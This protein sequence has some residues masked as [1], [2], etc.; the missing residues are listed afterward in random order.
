[1]S[2]TTVNDKFQLARAQAMHEREI[3]LQMSKSDHEDVAKCYS[4]LTR[5]RVAAPLCAAVSCALVGAVRFNLF[6]DRILSTALRRQAAMAAASV[7]YIFSTSAL[8]EV[9]TCRRVSRVQNA[10]LETG[11]YYPHSSYSLDTRHATLR[12]SKSRAL[13]IDSIAAICL[14]LASFGLADSLILSLFTFR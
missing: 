2:T 12:Y 10:E 1:M 5:V 9:A 7:F 8:Y 4:A 11:V 13:I 6:S 3:V 14:G